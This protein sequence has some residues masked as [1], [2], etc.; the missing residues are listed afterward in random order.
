MIRGW[1]AAFA[2]LVL[3]SSA[4]GQTA[5]GSVQGRVVDTTGAVLAGATLTLT[6][7]DT[8]VSARATSAQDGVYVFP[9]IAPGRYTLTVEKESFRQEVIT[10]LVVTVGQTLARP[11]TLA[12]GSIADVVT[13]AAPATELQ[14]RLS[15]VSEIVT[16]RRVQE[17][18]LNGKDFNKLVILA[19]GVV[20]TPASS[21]GSPAVSGARTTA[22]NYTLDGVSTN[23]ERVDGLPPGAGFSS[24]GNAL[25]NIVSTEA[26]Q[27]FRVVTSN[28]DATNGRGSGGQIN[29]VTKSGTN[30]PSGSAYFFGRHEA[31]DAKDYFN[32]GPYFRA[33]GSPKNPPFRQ[34]LYGVTTGGPMV[35]NKHFFFASYEGVRQRRETITPLT[36]LN[37]DFINLMPGDLGRL[38]RAVFIDGGVVP[39][40][41]NP[42]GAFSPLPAAQR[43]AAIAAGF[44]SHLFD[45][46]TDNAE[47]GTTLVSSVAQ[48]N[49]NQNAVLLRTDHALADAWRLSLRYGFNGNEALSGVVT[50][51]VREPRRWQSFAADA[52]WSM[53]PTQLLDIRLGRQVT[54]NWTVGA[55]PVDAKLAAVGVNAE[56]GIFV[57]PDS[58]GSRFIRIRGANAIVNDQPSTSLFAQHTWSRGPLLLKTGA[59]VRDVTIDFRSNIDLPS[60]SFTGF[61]G[62]NGLLGTAPGQAQATAATVTGTLF[63]RTVG[64]A[65]P[66]RSYRTTQQEYFVQADWRAAATLT[67]NVGLRYSYFGVYR[68]AENAVANLYA[69]DAGGTPVAGVSPFAFGREQNGFFPV[70]DDRRFYQP[71]RNNLQP[72]VGAAW[73]IGGRDAV[74][75]RAAYGRY[76]DR[77]AVLEFSDIVG[78]APFAQSTSAIQVPFVLGASVPAVQTVVPGLGIDPT[79]RNPWTD[80]FNSAIE[81][82]LWQGTTVGAGYVGARGHDLFRQQAVNATGSVPVAARPDPRFGNQGFLTNASSSQYDALQLNGHYRR[83]GL[84]VSAYYTWAR[85]LDD[86]SGAYGF[87]GAGPALVNLGASSSAGFQGG[88]AQWIDRPVSA[89]WGPST[90]DVRH[91]VVVSHLVDLPFGRGRRFVNGGGGLVDG[92][93]GGWSIVG[94][95][96]ARSG[97][98]FSITLGSDV[99][100]DG[101][102]DDRPMLLGGRLDDLYATG[103]GRTQYLVPRTDALQRLGTP[104]PVTDPAVPI[105]RNVFRA[106]AVVVYDLS[107]I[108]R[109]SLRAR[110]ALQVE[111]NVFNLFNRANLNAPIAD[112]SNARFGQVTSTLAGSHGAAGNPRQLQLGAKLTF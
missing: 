98:P 100:D 34:G 72:R 110:A 88:G 14:S 69:V 40:S 73:D 48:S 108:K 21:A 92:L 53:S 17:L 101:A 102:F 61:V 42:A 71:D 64:P 55:N 81:L 67:V 95:L 50:D 16:G 39:A 52:S 25:P 66:R 9:R 30:Q 36:L 41:G 2:W 46:V 93:V 3:A 56:T 68:E 109:V 6:N 35:R 5:S 97:L 58:T 89:D 28:A 65:T 32:T 29:I 82:R 45:G 94:L 20:T 90:F 10:D 8:G 76:F 112:L 74:V 23:D 26:I 22:N 47:A 63:G 79:L 1:L 70:T 111:V 11:V 107:L 96:Q 13:V 44:P 38:Y 49:F 86:V 57:S 60:Y 87:S 104:V 62:E 80:R 12:V 91:Q 33:D 24:L 37:A 51:Q 75:V 77:L 78:N 103:A 105:G 4:A 85:S 27:E 18:P 31:L 83:S 59:E 15:S 19:P 84:D 7:A 54:R 99:N 106:P 43:A